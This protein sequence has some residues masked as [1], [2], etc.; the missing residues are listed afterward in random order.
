MSSVLRL[1]GF[2]LLLVV[3]EEPIR[4][5]A[6]ER[7]CS[8]FGTSPP[9]E[10]FHVFFLFEQIATADVDDSAAMKAFCTMLDLV[11]FQMVFTAAQ[12]SKTIQEYHYKELSFWNGALSLLQRL[13]PLSDDL[14]NIFD[15]GLL[16]FLSLSFFLVLCSYLLLRSSVLNQ[17]EANSQAFLA[18]AT[19]MR[20]VLQVG[21]VS[22][23]FLSSLTF[24]CFSLD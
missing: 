10:F 11:G 3:P 5:Y 9:S 2:Y 19:C 8:L 4:A 12:E 22:L 16:S 23:C 18:Q 15:T 24:F 13:D 6:T 14:P 7:V 21:S 1:P 17:L 20:L